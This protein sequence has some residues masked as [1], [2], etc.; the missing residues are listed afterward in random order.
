ML[1]N[2]QMLS[3]SSA[4]GVKSLELNQRQPIAAIVTINRRNNTS[5]IVLPIANA[6]P[7]AVMANIALASIRNA[8]ITITII[9]GTTVVKARKPDAMSLTDQ[10]HALDRWLHRA[11]IGTMGQVR[12]DAFSGDFE[13]VVMTTLTA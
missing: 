4:M 5:V 3:R 1:A 2:N 9:T 7:L 13:A 6:T 10:P 8:I 12:L 11:P